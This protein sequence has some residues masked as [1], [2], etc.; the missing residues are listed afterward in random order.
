MALARDENYDTHTGKNLDPQIVNAARVYGQA[1]VGVGLPGIATAAEQGRAKPWVPENSLMPAVMSVDGDTTG[2]T[3]AADPP[4]LRLDTEKRVLKEV[5]V[6][7]L[8]GDQTDMFRMVYMSDDNT[9][10]IT[11]PATLAFPVGLTTRA[12][13]ATTADVMLLSLETLLAISLAGG[14]REDI[15]LGVVSGV[16]GG[17]GTFYTGRVA[18]YHGVIESTYGIVIEPLVGVGA[19]LDVNVEINGTNVTGGVIEWL[20]ADAAGT[21]KAGTAVTAANRLHHGDLIDL[22]TVEN[23]AST[24]GLMAIHAVVRKELGL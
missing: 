13:T 23:T 19:D 15:L 5:T 22:E 3:A 20:L 14:L 17:G 21:K 8:A 24:A 12:V 16:S 11:P 18:S 4:R 1:V 2:N 7:G 9:F 6:A 10:T